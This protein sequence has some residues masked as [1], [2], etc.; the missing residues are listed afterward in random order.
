MAA[1][2]FFYRTGRASLRRFAEYDV[3]TLHRHL[4][5]LTSHRFNLHDP[6]DHA[7]FLNL[8]QHH[9]YPTPLLDWTYSPFIAAYFALRNLRRE[10]L[11][12]DRRVRILAFR[13]KQWASDFERAQNLLVPFRQATL[14]EPLAINNPRVVPQQSMSMVTNI[15]DLETYIADRGKQKG[16]RYL[17]AIDLPAAERPKVMRELDLMGINACS[18]FPG[19]DGACQQL[20]E[21]FFE[22]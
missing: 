5:G 19:L 1:Q 6:L 15:D 13:F 20:K 4:S 14:L 21:R 2:G 22:P 12:P 9:G 17:Q 18:L 3:A 16:V 10:S 7:A 8:V 11:V